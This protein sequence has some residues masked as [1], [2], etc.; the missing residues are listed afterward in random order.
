MSIPDR[1]LRLNCTRCHDFTEYE[2][3]S[4]NREV[5][6]C[7]ECGKKHGSASL[8]AID[9]HATYRRDES[10]ELLEEPP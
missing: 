9:P 10:G 6:Y 2:R 4:D 3:D 1:P 7:E 8:F 5:V